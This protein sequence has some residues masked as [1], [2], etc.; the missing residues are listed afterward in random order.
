MNPWQGPLIDA[1]AHVGDPRYGSLASARRYLD[2]LGIRQAVLALGPGMPD[3]ASLLRARREMGDNVRFMGIPFGHTA[4]QRRELA[5]IQ[6]RLGISGMRLMPF[7]V[8]PNGEILR[9]LGEEGLCLYAINPYDSMEVTRLLL[10][11]LETHSGGRIACPHF[12]IPHTLE[13]RAG[14]PV[15]F[16]EL[17][18]HPRFHAILSRHGGVGSTKPY[19]HDDLRPWVEQLAELVTWERLM[20]GGEFPVFYQRNEQPEAVRDW[21]LHLGV[22]LT[23][24]D[25]ERFYQANA[26]RLL[27]DLPAPACTEVELPAWVEEQTDRD[28]QVYLFPGNRIFLPMQDFETLLGAFQ[29]TADDDPEPDFAGYLA[30]RLSEAARAMRRDGKDQPARPG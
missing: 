20:W 8:E 11:W 28:A 17:L 25:R 24:E 14:D 2:R 19:P 18:R 29:R 26:Q 16:R 7:E 27:F 3:F 9:R 12:L 5:E 4:E 1:Y 13:E 22:P 23:Q 30:G 6:I 10:E 15:L 21:L